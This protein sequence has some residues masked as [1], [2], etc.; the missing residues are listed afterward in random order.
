MGESLSLC[1]PRILMP[2]VIRSDGNSRCCT[3]SHDSIKCATDVTDCKRKQ[4]YTR[5]FS[6]FIPTARSASSLMAVSS[7]IGFG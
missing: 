6:I 3:L 5:L 1:V 4:S 2:S 7:T